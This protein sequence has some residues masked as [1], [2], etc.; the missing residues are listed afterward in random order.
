MWIQVQNAL[1]PI[2]PSCGGEQGSERGLGDVAE[3]VSNG[4][5]REKNKGGLGQGD[6]EELTSLG[7][8]GLC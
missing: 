6:R 7:H 1:P 3:K 4:Q 2:N 5:V 8:G